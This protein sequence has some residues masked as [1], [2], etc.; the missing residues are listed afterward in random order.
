M[1]N[2]W[3]IYFTDLKRII[4]NVPAL[5]LIVGLICLPS[6][7]SWINIL[8]SWNPYE[9]TS[10]IKVAVVNE[11]AGSTVMN[12]PIN[13]GKSII[14]SLHKNDKIG[15]VFVNQKEALHGVNHG[16]Y[17]ASILIPQDFS[18]RLGTVVTKNLV[19]A[20]IDYYVNEK[21]NAIAPKI[22]SKGASSIVSE[23]SSNFV[24][25]ANGA[26]FGI[27]NAIGVE[28][29]KEM[30]TIQRARKLIF[31]A[32]QDF[33]RFEQILHTATTDFHSIKGILQDTQKSMP[34]IENIVHT[35]QQFSDTANQILDKGS[36][37]IQ[38]AL[39]FIKQ[40]L[41]TLQG[42]AEASKDIQ[43][44]LLDKTSTPTLVDAAVER[45]IP[46]FEHG[47]QIATVARDWFTHLN[48]LSKG[49]LFHSYIDRLDRIMDTLKQQKAVTQ[50]I[51][52]A[53]QR[54]EEVA[55]TLITRLEDLSQQA[56]QDL[57]YLVEH[58]DSDITPKVNEVIN[59][60]K[61]TSKEISQVLNRASSKLPEVN[62]LLSDANQGLKLGDQTL[63]VIQHELPLIKQ[64]IT[65][66]ADKIRDFEKQGDITQIVD[67]LHNDAEKE[68]VFFANPVKLKEID[69]F[70]IAN[71]GSAMSPFY[72]TLSLWVGALLLVSLMTVEVNHSEINYAPY[73]VY[74]GRFLTFV[75][76]A[77]AQSIV[78]TAGGLYILGIYAKSPM[79][80]ILFGVLLSSVF[81]LIVYTLVS[82]FGNVG[83]ALG[84]VM[85]VLQL[86]GAGGTFPVQ[87]TPPFFQ[88]IH[89]YLPFTYGISL[90]REATGGILWDV[91]KQDLLI[92]ALCAV[93]ALVF[94]LLLKKPLNKVSHGFVEKIKETKL[95]H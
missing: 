91:V 74:F 43:S 39:P 30:P 68:S 35:G 36:Q 27:F 21:I 25:T 15:W 40:D 7:Y 78:D 3:R 50:E 83:K 47:V 26:I 31:S 67:M 51:Q 42:A 94:G 73:Q 70:P 53:R 37:G 41:T 34:L 22:T 14:D 66:T 29:S 65:S 95:I 79:G 45:A 93:I 46:Q 63:P 48:N 56:D 72:T 9:S 71:Y 88:A 55:Q 61:D 84:I 86:A 20:E 76:L 90:M 92:L 4:I 89:P 52:A 54:G 57:G 8:A 10:G 1:R 5:I 58:F 16:D 11:D 80:I 12:K 62:K 18:A 23:V 17:Y 75:T 32:E 33:P 49:R 64:Q 6:V 13:I 85:L 2:I 44:A 19:P 24:K 82:V 59:K 81:M 69:L 77:I 38:E 60:A 28:L 87:M